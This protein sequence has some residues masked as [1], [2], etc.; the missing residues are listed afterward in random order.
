MFQLELPAGQNKTTST[1]IVDIVLN[2]NCIDVIGPHD[3]SD[4]DTYETFQTVTEKVQLYTALICA[5]AGMKQ[6]IIF[7]KSALEQKSRPS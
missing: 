1:M 2:K 3:L 7:K 4:V 6:Y 5:L